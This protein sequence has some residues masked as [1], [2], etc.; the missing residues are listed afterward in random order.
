DERDAP[1]EALVDSVSERL[2]QGGHHRE[3]ARSSEPFEH[4]RL[5]EIG[6]ERDT[7]KGR[8]RGVREKRSDALGRPGT[9]GRTEELELDPLKQLRLECVQA[10]GERLEAL[11]LFEPAEE[12]NALDSPVGDR[13]SRLLLAGGSGTRQVWNHERSGRQ[14]PPLLLHPFYDIFAGADDDVRELERCSLEG[15]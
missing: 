3:R 10:C 11:A 4:L 15:A 2:P 8:S 6:R 7:A 13:G 5:I 9:R 1:L 14:P 12:G